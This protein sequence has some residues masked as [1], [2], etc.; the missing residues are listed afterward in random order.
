MGGRVS[1]PHW[2]G[3]SQS[4]P[5]SCLAPAPPLPPQPICQLPVRSTKPLTE[6]MDFELQTSKRHRTHPMQTRTT[7]S[8]VCVGGSLSLAPMG[9]LFPSP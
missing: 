8:K 3:P 6:P 5:L 2:P 1:H 9:A 4:P 7:P